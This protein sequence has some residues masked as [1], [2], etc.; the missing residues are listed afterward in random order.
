MFVILGMNEIKLSIKMKAKD[1]TK[2]RAY[3][4]NLFIQWLIV[5]INKYAK[6]LPL[7]VDQTLFL[8]SSSLPYKAFTHQSILIC[9]QNDKCLEGEEQH[10]GGGVSPAD[11]SVTNEQGW[12]RDTLSCIFHPPICLMWNRM[13]IY[14]FS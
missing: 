12:L 10:K 11:R 3:L 7:I 2:L 6:M 4:C 13:K 9:W 14:P 8:L 1:G 5:L